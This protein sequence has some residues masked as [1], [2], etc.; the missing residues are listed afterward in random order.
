[1]LH[2]LRSKA[3]DAAVMPVVATGRYLPFADTTQRRQV[4]LWNTS[5]TSKVASTEPVDERRSA[6]SSTHAMDHR[7]PVILRTA[8]DATSAM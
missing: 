5:G 3:P 2:A 6:S 1:M 4:T 8:R 7:P